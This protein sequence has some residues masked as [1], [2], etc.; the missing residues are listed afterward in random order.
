MTEGGLTADTTAATSDAATEP[1]TGTA[2]EAIP[3]RENGNNPE[4]AASMTPEDWATL[5]RP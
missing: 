4:E 3:G 2:A 5:A 1:T